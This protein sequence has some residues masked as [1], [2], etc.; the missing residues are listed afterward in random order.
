MNLADLR[1]RIV[2]ETNRED[3]LDAPGGD[4]TQADSGTLDQCIQ[5]AID[6]YAS[7]RF[8]FNEATVLAQTESGNDLIFVPAP[9]R[10]ID[11]ISYTLWG[12]RYALR[13]QDYTLIDAWQGY[14]ANSGQPTD[15]SVSNGMIRFYP[16]PDQ[17]YPI[18]VLGLVN[19]PLDYTDGNSENAW[20]NE[21]QDLI[22]ARAR[23][24]LCRDYFRDEKGALLAQ[25]A[26]REALE[27]LQAEAT[28][29][30]GTGRIRGA[31]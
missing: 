5:R 19:L 29:R 12:N 28:T 30:L 2:A 15:Y 24:L 25:G 18:T 6:Y 4:P 31:M 23:F 14:G 21:G 13:K 17:A 1:S 27:E 8:A 3:L 11:R 16:T 22:A 10:T 26:V 7:K 9:I 20:T